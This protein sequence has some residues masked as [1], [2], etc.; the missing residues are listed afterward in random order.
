[1]PSHPSSACHRNQRPC[2]SYCAATMQLCRMLNSFFCSSTRDWNVLPTDPSTFHTI[3]AF[4]TL[5]NTKASSQH[6]FQHHH[7]H[8]ARNIVYLATVRLSSMRGCTFMEKEKSK[9][10]KSLAVAEMGDSGHNRHGPKRGGVL[11]PFRGAL[12]TRLIQCGLRRGL[13]SY[14]V[15]SSSIQPFGHN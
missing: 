13:L 10:N 6:C 3:D 11:C 14:Q 12:G 9:E 8:P 2:L 4:K 15:V 7:V 5:L 1:M